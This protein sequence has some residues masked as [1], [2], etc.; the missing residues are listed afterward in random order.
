[1]VHTFAP[2]RGLAENRS[3][4]TNSHLKAVVIAL[5]LA[6][7]PLHAQYE[8]R[9]WSGAPATSANAPAPELRID[10]NHSTADGLMRVP[11][12]SRSWAERIVRYRPYRTKQD[13]LDRGVVTIEVYDRIKDFVIAHRDKQ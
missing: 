11:G 3:V 13:I 9:D 10:I 4:D 8:D 1:M 2:L 5:A 6:A 7:V 12:M